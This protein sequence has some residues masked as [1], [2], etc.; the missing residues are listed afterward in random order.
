MWSEIATNLAAASTVQQHVRDH[1]ADF[2]AVRTFI[3]DGAIWLNAR[4]GRVE[5]LATSCCRLYVD[6]RTGLLRR[7]KHYRSWQRKAREDR[8]EADRAR[9]TRM[10]ELAPD[11]QLHLLDDG[12]WWEV[13]LAPLPTRRQR[14]PAPGT[15]VMRQYDVVDGQAY[16]DVVLRPGLSQLPPGELYG[17]HGVY[18]RAKRQLSRR[19]AASL[20]LPR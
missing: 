7:N 20:D 3:K 15:G 16:V 4:H 9:A 2:V 1:V 17:R 14:A 19:E 6:P 8:A 12:A 10:R 11:T 13:K 18:A 5:P